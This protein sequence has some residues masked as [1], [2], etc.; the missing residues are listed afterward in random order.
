MF[1]GGSTL[2]NNT[3]TGLF[4]Q[5]TINNAP[6]NPATMTASI[7]QPVQQ[8]LP[9][10]SLLQSTNQPPVIDSQSKR[11]TSYFVDVPSRST[12]TLSSS[13]FG[14]SNKLRGFASSTAGLSRNGTGLSSTITMTVPGNGLKGSTATRNGNGT[15]NLLGPDAF[16]GKSASLGSEN[17]PSPKKLVLDK[18]MDPNEVFGRAAAK[19]GSLG[20]GP[21]VSFNPTMSA[22]ARDKELFTVP[23]PAPT[24]AP[25]EKVSSTKKTSSGAGEDESSKEIQE[26]DYYIKPSLSVL[27]SLSNRELSSFEGL[28]VGRKGFGEIQFLEPVDLTA[29]P[30]LSALLG[31]IVQIENKEAIIYPDDGND[32]KPPPGEG[33]NVKA[34]IILDGCFA[35]DKATGSPIRDENHPSFI[36]NVKKLKNMKR[37][38]FDSYDNKTG[39]WAF[40]AERF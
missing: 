16:L 33:L 27:R 2:G 34:R 40:I 19:N 23:S 13:K 32:A 39:R 12:L 31:R 22:A 38:Q 21:K 10:F 11:M 37:T 18:R 15:S 36:K 8:N 4:G 29:L 20:G 28:V 25:A 14:N 3:G 35:I 17:K 9:I 5:S 1:G 30:R 7:A 26:G 6:Q 24:P